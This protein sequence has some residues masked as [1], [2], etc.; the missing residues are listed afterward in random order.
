ME[1]QGPAAEALVQEAVE[2]LVD[3]DDWFLQEVDKGLAAADRGEFVGTRRDA[4]IYRPPVFQLTYPRKGAKSPRVLCSLRALRLCVII[5]C[6][7][8]HRRSKA[9]V[10]FA[11]VFF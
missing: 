11:W 6:I 5:L 2:R 8:T 3:Y 1:V 9:R 7:P 4:Q 10:R